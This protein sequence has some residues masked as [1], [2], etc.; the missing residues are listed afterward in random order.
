MINFVL[1]RFYPKP[2]LLIDAMCHI[3][4][5]YVYS[6]CI[7]NSMSKNTGI[8]KSHS[9]INPRPKAKR[10]HDRGFTMEGSDKLSAVSMEKLVPDKRADSLQ[11]LS[12]GNHD[13]KCVTIN[14]SGLNSKL[15][16][17]I[18]DQYLANFDIILTVETNCESPILKIQCLV[19]SAIFPRKSLNLTESISMVAF[20]ES[21]LW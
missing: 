18:L 8:N 21:V 16:N 13:I 3:N 19:N 10:D 17:G 6:N 7:S 5:N 1:S 11:N 9:S 2:I 12:K 20:M 4:R 15:N 14:V